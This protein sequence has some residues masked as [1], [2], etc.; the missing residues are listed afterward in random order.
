MKDHGGFMKVRG[1]P[2]VFS[3]V[4]TLLVANG[5]ARAQDRTDRVEHYDRAKNNARTTRTGAIV[6]EDPAELVIRAGLT[7]KVDYRIPVG[8]ILEV[9]YEGEPGEAATARSAERSKDFERA[10]RFYQE[11]AKKAPAG[12]KLMQAHLRFKVA[13]L[14]VR[15]AEGGAGQRLIAVEALQKFKN[16]F[17][18]AR[19]IVE[20]LDLLGRLLMTD[21]Q[22]TQ[23]V[24][25]AFQNLKKKYA[26]NKEIVSR[27][28]LFESQLRLQEARSLVKTQPDVARQKYAEAQKALQG[29]LAGADKGTGLD[30]RINLAECQAAL[31]QK[32]QALK[33]LE[34]ILRDAPDD[35]TKAAV[36]L[37]RGNCYRLGRQ[38]REAMW[39]YLWVDVVYFQD[40]EQNA[41]ALYYLQEVF[42]GLNDETRA[43]QCKE[44]L[45]TEARFKD[46]RYQK[47]MA[48]R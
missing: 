43:R 30:I 38:F 34:A 48:G 16:D 10:L 46:T 4:F 18:D 12:N 6:S 32:D 29:M 9:T 20:C 26:N 17:P 23:E 40:A 13:K 33:D 45:Q 11:A 2:F 25:D 27:C 39:E 3:L 36:Y 47:L 7:K 42:A 37:A 35:R 22:S 8:D 19:Q 44:R 31:D 5:A 28:D 24:V 15:Q 41:E 21:G 14:L 1:S